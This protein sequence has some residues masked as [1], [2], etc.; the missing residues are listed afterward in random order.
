MDYIDKYVYIVYKCEYN[1]Q[2]GD[3]PK[4]KRGQTGVCG[5]IRMLVVK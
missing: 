1:I 4:A 5:V 3:G 2:S